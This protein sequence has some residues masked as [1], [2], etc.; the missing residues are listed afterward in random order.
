MTSPTRLT[1]M[2]KWVGCAFR[3]KHWAVYVEVEQSLKINEVLLTGHPWPVGVLKSYVL[4]CCAF[5]LLGLKIVVCFQIVLKWCALNLM[6][7]VVELYQSDC[8]RH[9][10]PL[11][12]RPV[13]NASSYRRHQTLEV[14]SYWLFL[15]LVLHSSSDYKYLLVTC[16]H[17]FVQLI[18]NL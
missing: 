2:W 3:L 8:K 10:L 14:S 7:W 16:P 12:P 15:V 5:K 9:L 13:S 1:I 18:C 17:C 4:K 11:C 6:T